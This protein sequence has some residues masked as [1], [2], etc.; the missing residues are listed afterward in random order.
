MPKPMN[1]RL[2]L[3]SVGGD[4]A[5]Q[6]ELFALLT[7]GIIESLENGLL[8]PADAITVFFNLENCRCVRETLPAKAADQVMGRGVQLPDLAAAL[9][10]EEADTEFQ[11]ELTAIRRLCLGLLEQHRRVA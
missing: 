4:T 1:L 11:R 2:V 5:R 6:L 9:N 8:S 3:D 7:L 10:P